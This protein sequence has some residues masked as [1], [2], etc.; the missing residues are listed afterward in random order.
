MI[1]LFLLVHFYDFSF[2]KPNKHSNVL[3]PL[4]QKVTVYKQMVLLL[5]LLRVVC[6][7]VPMLRDLTQNG[8]IR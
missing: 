6:S 2:L 1:L 3:L 4:I 8:T 7:P 5:F